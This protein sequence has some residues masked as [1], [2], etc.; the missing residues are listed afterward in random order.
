MSAPTTW[1]PRTEPHG[2]L[3]HLLF[4]WRLYAKR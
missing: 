2:L 4:R 3:A 1:T